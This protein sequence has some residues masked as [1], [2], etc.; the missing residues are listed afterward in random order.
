[1]NLFY[2]SLFSSFL[3]LLL[4]YYAVPSGYP[5][6]TVDRAVLE[7]DGRAEVHGVIVKE[8]TS[9]KGK[10]ISIMKGESETLFAVVKGKRGLGRNSISGRLS[11]YSEECWLFEE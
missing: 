2:L 11:K 7:C 1:M 6:K 8:F 5:P 9:R 3:G 10:L 4:V